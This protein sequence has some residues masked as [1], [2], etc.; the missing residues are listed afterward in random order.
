VRRPL[1][2]KGTL[3]LL[4]PVRTVV[5]RY[6]GVRGRVASNGDRAIEVE[7]FLELKAA[8]VIIACSAGAFLLEQPFHLVFIVIGARTIYTPDF[9]VIGHDGPVAIEVKPGDHATKEEDV[10]RFD[11]IADLLQGHGI[12]FQVW[13]R[14]QIEV[15]PRWSSVLA[16]LPYRRVGMKPE[17][18][19]RIRKA[20]KLSQ[21]CNTI[22]ALAAT[23][24]VEKEVVLRMILDGD[25]FIDFN[26]PLTSDAHVSDMPFAHQLWPARQQTGEL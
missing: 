20:I 14:S 16:L 1:I 25:L 13:R 24:Q 19:G 22:C 3:A 21:H 10:A 23:A 17:D 9:L 5:R 26:E 8:R 15:Q 7:S 18:R 4:R 12:Q 6:R 11:L 2:D